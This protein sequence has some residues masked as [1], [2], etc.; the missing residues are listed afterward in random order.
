MQH[1]VDRQ[2]SGIHLAFIHKQMRTCGKNMVQAKW[3][4]YYSLLAK[5]V[6]NKRVR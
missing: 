2:M 3:Q 5:Y 6:R 1:V 4:S